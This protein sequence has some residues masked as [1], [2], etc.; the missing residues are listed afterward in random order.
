[1]SDAE[2]FIER[3]SGTIETLNR[4]Y[5]QAMWDLDTTGA[6]LHQETLVQA[7]LELHR[8][9][10]SASDAARV[11]AW[12]SQAGHAPETQ[13]VLD[14][15]SL[16]YLGNRQSDAAAA[17]VAELEARLR[18]L[19]ANFRG[20]V[21]GQ[22]ISTN[23]IRDI[24]LQGSDSEQRRLAWAASKQVG[25]QA[26]ELILELVG[27][28]NAS[29]RQLS[30]RDYYAY[31]L[32][33]Q[34][35]DEPQLFNLMQELDRSTA[36]PF[37]ALKEETDG[38]ARRRC[39]LGASAELYPWH[40]DD[41]FFQE[42]QLASRMELD[43]LF[44]GQDYIRLAHETFE[45]TGLDVRSVLEL[46]DLAERQGKSQH[47]YCMCLGH[48][49]AVVRVMANIRANLAQTTTLLHELG[50]AV[51]YQGA[52]PRQ[53]YVLRDAAHPSTTE[54]IALLFGRL[55]Y[56]SAWLQDVLG[57]AP[58]QGRAI[59]QHTRQHMRFKML[60]FT[61]WVLV[62]VHF[63]RALY[64]DP[65]QDLNAL[66]WDLV[67]RFQGLRRP[68]GRDMPDWAT[69]P[70]IAQWPVYYHNYIMG[71]L[72][73]SQIQHYIENVLGNTAMIRQPQ[74]GPWLREHLFRCGKLRPW[75]AALA[76][77]TGEMLNPEY[78]LRQYVLN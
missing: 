25:P 2:G 32:E 46:S 29:A 38:R 63:E 72:T 24:L 33:L 34:E 50:H 59:G 35:T 15:L 60:V 52:D 37:A 77:L 21:A 76:R 75:N 55:T 56:D 58:E 30:Y 78:F 13:R 12:R 71:E 5:H 41:E 62:M 10:S 27:V 16:E 1:M 4:R 17:R 65:R 44:H 14:L 49:P 47:A 19:L 64:A 42:A 67:E 57:L 66:W 20:T 73:A 9:F 61:R 70:H 22:A 45:R 68:P 40:Y 74:T 11:Q 6:A 31:A 54:A 3:L 18:L 7:R 48:D 26:A 43:Q 51:Y 8:L 53:Q 28:R 69:K 39:G 36:Q 23:A